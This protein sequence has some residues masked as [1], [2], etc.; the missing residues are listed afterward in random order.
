MRNMTCRIVHSMR[1]LQD[2]VR[3]ERTLEACVAQLLLS[4]DYTAAPLHSGC[5]RISPALRGREREMR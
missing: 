2:V 3:R 5:F 4:A 1:E